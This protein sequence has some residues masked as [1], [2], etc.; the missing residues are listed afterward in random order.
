MYRRL[1]HS[2]DG[3][4]HIFKFELMLAVSRQF[5]GSLLTMLLILLRAHLSVIQCSRLWYFFS[6]FSLSMCC[7]YLCSGTEVYVSQLP[8]AIT[9]V[10]LLFIQVMQNACLTCI[11]KK[12][13]YYWQSKMLVKA[14]DLWHS[15]EMHPA[16]SLFFGK[17]VKREKK[18][19]KLKKNN[20]NISF[21]QWQ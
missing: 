5:P 10:F 7:A 19:L 9:E 18:I 14:L 4:F 21:T 2:C 1:T 12:R 17:E 13:L 11:K 15:V 8:S 16:S 6:F 20:N 3:H